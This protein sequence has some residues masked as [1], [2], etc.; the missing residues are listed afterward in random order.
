MRLEPLLLT[1]T[2]FILTY[3]LAVLT[4]I[5]LWLKVIARAD[6]EKLKKRKRAVCLVAVILLI[7][8]SS[9]YIQVWIQT[10]LYAGVLTPTVNKALSINYDDKQILSLRVL[11]I[12]E[13][14]AKVYVI[15]PCST[16]PPLNQNRFV[17]Q[18]INISKHNGQWQY[19]DDYDVVWSDCGNADGNI[20]PPYAAKG[21]YK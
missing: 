3:L 21:D 4:I 16:S 18:I 8:P 15:T 17:G 1:I 12:T 19:M 11:S 7:L 13:T 20:F 9:P 6:Y 5:A 14:S 10:V 2:Y